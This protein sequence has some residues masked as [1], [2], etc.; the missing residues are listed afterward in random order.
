M[1][2]KDF[3]KLNLIIPKD[4]PEWPYKVLNKSDGEEDNPFYTVFG[5]IILEIKGTREHPHHF[6]ILRKA[7]ASLHM[8]GPLSRIWYDTI[9]KV[10]SFIIIHDNR[11]E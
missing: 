9:Y 3:L 2:P 11:D 1:N 8:E 4:L 6:R 7:C 10:Y 5:N